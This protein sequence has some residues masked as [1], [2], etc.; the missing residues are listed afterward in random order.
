VTTLPAP[1]ANTPSALKKWT[2]TAILGVADVR[3]VDEPD[4]PRVSA[5]SPI[6][7]KLEAASSLC[8]F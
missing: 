3:K 7:R 6:A 4:D 2:L 1:G 5:G 8:R